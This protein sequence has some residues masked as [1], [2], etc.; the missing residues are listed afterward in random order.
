ELLRAHPL[1]FV[2]RELRAMV[3]DRDWTL[4]EVLKLPA[5]DGPVPTLPTDWREP[6]AVQRSRESFVRTQW[7][8]CM[9]YLQGPLAMLLGVCTMAA[10]QGRPSAKLIELRDRCAQ[11]IK[12]H[13]PEPQLDR[14][15]TDLREL[16]S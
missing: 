11:I 10:Q 12:L 14:I 8:E 5:R 15:D 6:T 13:V 9:H 7:R 4:T 1:A 16:V 2:R 3:D